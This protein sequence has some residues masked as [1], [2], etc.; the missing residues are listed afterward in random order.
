MVTALRKI[1][2]RVWHWIPSWG[3]FSW[4]HRPSAESP[5]F[6]Y[7]GPSP[8]DE[9]IYDPGTDTYY[10]ILYPKELREANKGKPVL[11]RVV[12][13]DPAGANGQPE[14]DRQTPAPEQQS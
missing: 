4:S 14:P 3:I 2:L 1:L 10:G 11:V 8:Y 9:V 5:S 12:G 7:L 13:E 6:K